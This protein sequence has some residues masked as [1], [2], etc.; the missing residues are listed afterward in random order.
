MG[1]G[2]EPD[3][4][5]AQE[6]YRVSTYKN[7]NLP[8][9]KHVLAKSGFYCTQ[10]GDT[11]RCYKCKFE[12][13][14]SKATLAEI[15]EGHKTRAPACNEVDNTD[16]VQRRSKKFVSYDSLRFEKERLETFINWPVS[17][18]Q[19][20]ELARDGF[21]YLRTEDHCACVFCRGIVGSWEEG[22][23]PRGEHQRHF[24]HCPFIKGQPVG[25]IPIEHSQ[26]ISRL[27]P[28][29]ETFNLPSFHSSD[30]CGTGRLMSGSYAEKSKSIKV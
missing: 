3:R 24:P 19:P 7:H 17:W 27:S 8:I 14:A 1:D 23:T 28:R 22:D 9:D 18:L 10:K 12:I 30:V 2:S 5:L 13:D 15:D 26:I 6:E 20:A 25:N 21:Y 4:L 16:Q 11:V 29:S